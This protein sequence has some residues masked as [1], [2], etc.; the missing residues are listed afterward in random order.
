M[1]VQALGQK[2][3]PLSEVEFWV[4]R[5]AELS[6]MLAQLKGPGA[7]AMAASLKAAGSTYAGALDRCIESQ[8]SLY[9]KGIAC[10]LD[11]G[12]RPTI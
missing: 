12:H 11:G 6:G 1:F 3:T 9:Y 7:L 5:A 4:N 2:A 8:N 10:Q